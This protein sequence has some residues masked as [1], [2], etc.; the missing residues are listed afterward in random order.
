MNVYYF[1]NDDMHVFI[2]FI[3]CVCIFREH[4]NSSRNDASIFNLRGQNGEFR[5]VFKIIG[6]HKIKLGIFTQNLFSTKLILFFGVTKK[7]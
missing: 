5:E 3:F 1:Y 7:K 4:D 2:F 6:K